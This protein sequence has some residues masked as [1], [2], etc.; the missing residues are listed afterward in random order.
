M[1]IVLFPV[2]G[3]S[4]N[5]FGQSMRLIFITLLATLAAGNA[6]AS[7]VMYLANEGLLVRSANSKVLFD[8]IFRNN[9]NNYQ[10]VPA[11][12]EA[13]M[14][15]AEPPFDD[16][17]AVFVSHAHGDHFSASD[18][19]R[20]LRRNSGVVLYA[21]AEATESLLFFVE[22]DEQELL[23]RIVGMDINYGDPA[24]EVAAGDITIE[25]FHIPHAG[26]PDR[27]PEVQNIAFR[28]TLDDITVLHMGDADTRDQH[29][30]IDA[31]RWAARH[32]D[33][34]FPP[35][36]YFTSENGVAVMRD[37][38]TP[39]MAVGVH[40]P[41]KLDP[42]YSAGLEDVDL[43]RRPGETRSISDSGE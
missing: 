34:A 42:R 30:E 29:F 20:Y 23:S 17:S 38:L 18:M 32:I 41:I 19:L 37:R 40:V 26:W 39:G 24:M 16:V 12:I 25:A 5:D 3:D 27:K 11:E 36:W 33:A 15:A 1:V 4:T 22:D 35:Y 2:G 14:F 6:I 21:P 31:E 43:F 9:Y 10:L 13:K 8:P 7:E 28:V